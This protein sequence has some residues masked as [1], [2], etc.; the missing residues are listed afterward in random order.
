MLVVVLV[1]VV[2]VVA[3]AAGVVVVVFEVVV[4]SVEFAVV[5]FVVLVKSLSILR[6]T[7]V[8]SW[9]AD[10]TQAIDS[11]CASRLQ[12]SPTAFCD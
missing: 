5:L 6:T 7:G 8:N 12:A 2:S 10:D 9:H 3:F 1:Y 4:V 11:H